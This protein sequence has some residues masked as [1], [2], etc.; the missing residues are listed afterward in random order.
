MSNIFKKVKR[1]YADASR[2]IAYYYG[3][4]CADLYRKSGFNPLTVGVYLKDGIHPNAVGGAR[5]A[6]IVIA[7]F[8]EG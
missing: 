3:L 6:D 1:K 4:L 5:I 7:T 8:L 2:E